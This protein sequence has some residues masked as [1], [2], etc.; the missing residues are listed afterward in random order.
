MPK[1]FWPTVIH[2]V[3]F[4]IPVD[5]PAIAVTVARGKVDRA[6]DINAANQSTFQACP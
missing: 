6:N 4:S 3:V 1:R 2:I 5:G